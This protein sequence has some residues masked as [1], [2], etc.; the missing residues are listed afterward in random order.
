[1]VKSAARLELGDAGP[2]L[3]PVGQPLRPRV[4]LLLGEVLGGQTLARGL[5]RVHPGL[6]VL[7]LE[8]GEGEQEVAQIALGIHHDGRDPVDGRF[9]QQPDAQAG[10]A[11]ARHAHAHAVGDEVFRVV[12]EE[13][14]RLFRTK[15]VF[16]AEVERPQLFEVFHGRSSL[17]HSG[18]V[19]DTQ[20]TFEYNNNAFRPKS[21][22]WL[23]PFTVPGRLAPFPGRVCMHR[24]AP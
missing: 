2:V 22:P 20:W 11:A 15:I 10:L 21:E 5:L 13:V 14:A 12:E 23:S 8:V 16:P 7:G 19:R 4:R 1:M 24:G 17:T 3:A 6:E 18:T 9:L